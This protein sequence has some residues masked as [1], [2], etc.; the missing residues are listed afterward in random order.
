MI[1]I[2]NF[3][4]G[5]IQYASYELLNFK[6]FD[7]WFSSDI[8]SLTIIL[9]ILL[10][11]KFPWS[12]TLTYETYDNNKNKIY[13]PCDIFNNYITNNDPYKYW[14]ILLSK[15]FHKNDTCLPIYNH[16]LNY[17]FNKNYNERNDISYIKYLISLI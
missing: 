11:N 13:E 14:N 2:L 8:W 16:L 9:Y 10:F 6:K 1:L 15:I 3:V 7:N 12:N 4:R 17:G 5:T